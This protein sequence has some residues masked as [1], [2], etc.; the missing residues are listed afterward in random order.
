MHRIC[1][2]APPKPARSRRISRIRTLCSASPSS[3]RP[4]CLL[5][6]GPPCSWV[7]L[8]PIPDLNNFDSRK[9]AQSTKIY[10]R[11][12]KT[13][14]YDLNHDVRRNVVPLSQISP[15]LQQATISIEDSGFYQHGGVS[16]TGVARAFITDITRG[17]FAQGG[18]TITQQVG[19]EYAPVGAEEHHAQG[20]GMDTGLEAREEVHQGP[21]TRVLFQRHALRRD[22]LRRG[23]RQPRLLREVPQASSTWPRAP[24]W[25]PFPSFRPTIPRTATTRA[26]LDTR[27]NIVLSV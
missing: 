14:L 21:D 15:Y 17:E 25:P 22:A 6:A 2:A 20:P 23:S 9:V 16:F 13:V 8:T 4:F 11:T 27:K 1:S 3:R 10:D 26:A 12:G 5:S 18:S 24:T 7:S 19:E